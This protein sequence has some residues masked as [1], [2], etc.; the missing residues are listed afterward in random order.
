MLRHKLRRFSVRLAPATVVFGAD[1][2]D[3]I[4]K[5]IVLRG[6]RK[7]SAKDNRTKNHQQP[8]SFLSHCLFHPSEYMVTESKCN[9]NVT[10]TTNV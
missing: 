5:L 1:Q 6:G 7:A 10:V 8:L 2:H 3:A 4:H 9:R